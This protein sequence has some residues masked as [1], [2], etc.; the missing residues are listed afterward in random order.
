LNRKDLVLDFS[1]VPAD[2]PIPCPRQVRSLKVA[3][4]GI[5]DHLDLLQSPTQQV[6][7]ALV[8]GKRVALYR[9]SGHPAPAPAASEPVLIPQDRKHLLAPTFHIESNH[10]DIVRKAESLSAGAPT[11]REKMERLVHWVAGQVQDEPAESTS[12]LEVLQKKRG[13]CQAHT[14]LYT[15]FARA[16]GIPT[17]LAGGL[18]YIEDTGF[19]YH[20]WAESFVEN[21]WIPVDPTFGQVWVDATHIKL[22]EGPWWSSVLRMGAVIGRINA[23]VLD[24]D[25]ACD[26]VDQPASKSP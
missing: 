25:G 12:A 4:E 14:L 9:V 6:D 20:S 3:F 8:D 11:P 18:V 17:R 13:E 10:P 16:L 2:K 23:R 19:L 24:F 1:L 26:N 7:M 22:V 15:A 21:G 5:A